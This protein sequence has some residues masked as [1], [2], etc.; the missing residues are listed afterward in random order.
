MLS[1]LAHNPHFTHSERQ[2]IRRNDENDGLSI[3][4]KK[5]NSTNKTSSAIGSSSSSSSS[6][7]KTPSTKGLKTPGGKQSTTKRRALGDISNRKQA[8]AASLRGGLDGKASSSIKPQQQQLTVKAKNGKNLSKSVSFHLDTKK[9]LSINDSSFGESL[10]GSYVV[11]E[12]KQQSMSKMQLVSQNK[13]EDIDDDVEDI[14]LPA[15]RLYGEGPNTLFDDIACSFELYKDDDEDPWDTI[16]TTLLSEREEEIQA[17][18]K[19]LEEKIEKLYQDDLR[20]LMTSLNVVDDKHGDGRDDKLVEA[21]TL[22][23]DDG[24]DVFRLASWSN[25]VRW[26]DDDISL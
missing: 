17:N 7:H 21:L 14:E 10:N 15:G 23:M 3:A 8:N 20:V 11:Q 12:Q 13:E 25:R 18:E 6:I 1:S 2:N 5:M 9:Q 26:D 19:R 24:D 16:A 4:S 22:T